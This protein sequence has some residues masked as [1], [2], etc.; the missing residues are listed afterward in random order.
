MKNKLRI[1]SICLVMLLLLTAI[2]P[3]ALADGIQPRYEIINQI[4]A[5]LTIGFLGKANCKSL[6][7]ARGSTPVRLICRLQRLENGS[8]HTIKTWEATGTSIVELTKSQYVA[9]GYTYRVYTVG[10]AYDA[11]N[12]LVEQESVEHVVVY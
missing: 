2:I 6:L 7:T 3:P 11:N 12:V 5:S 10:Y 1:I 9:S 4:E 8:W